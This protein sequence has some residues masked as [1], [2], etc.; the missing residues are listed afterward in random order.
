[1]RRIQVILFV[2]S[3]SFFAAAARA[4]V[5]TGL[6]LFG[7]FSGGP[8]DTVN[9]ANLNVTFSI[10]VENKAGRGLPFNYNLT[11]DTSVWYPV[12]SSGMQIWQPVTNWGWSTW[13]AAQTGYV[14]YN[15]TTNYCNYYTGYTYV[16]VPYE[17]IFSNFIYYDKGGT[18]HPFPGQNAIWANPGGGCPS[19]TNS[20]DN[21]AVATDGSGYVFNGKN[22]NLTSPQGQT[23]TPPFQAS[24]GAGST[25]DANGNTISNGS[26]GVYTDTLG[27]TALTVAGSAPSPV[28][29][30]YPAA[31]GSATVTVKY[32]SKTVRTNFGCSG[33]S[34]F[35]PTTENL[36]TEIDMPDINSNPSDKYT[37]TYEA[38][39]NYSGDYTGRL[40]S[41]TLPSG[42]TINYT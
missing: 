15:Q 13:T 40:A 8:F 18:P 17:V 28:T 29:F 3:V 14:Y 19:G 9:N 20:Y 35:G 30:T 22:W 5:Q 36:V 37:F 41:V 39:P 26:N 25:T 2:L 10:P 34:E 23:I 42:G 16:Q 21:G 31:G 27:V 33:I 38:T 32:V 1:M 6:P 12:G 24:T 11:Y 4:Q 7:S